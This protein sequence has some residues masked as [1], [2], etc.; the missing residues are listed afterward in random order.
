MKTKYFKVFLTGRTGKAKNIL[1]CIFLILYGVTSHRCRAE[2]LEM[3]NLLICS[4]LWVILSSV[5][6]ATSDTLSWF[7]SL[8]GF[9]ME[10][11][12]VLEGTQF[13]TEHERSYDVIS[14]FYQSHS[15]VQ[16]HL[17]ATSQSCVKWTRRFVLWEA[18]AVRLFRV[19]QRFFG[20][21]AWVLV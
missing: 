17:A 3:T 20:A 7:Y 21:A 13:F 5:S 1:L 2:V 16:I 6:R 10:E 8:R 4:L 14:V 19:F 12:G 15:W 11:D 18:A 9:D